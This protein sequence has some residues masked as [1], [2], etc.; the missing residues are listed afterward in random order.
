MV[1]DG[2][3]FV[4]ICFDFE[5]CVETYSLKMF[6]RITKKLIKNRNNVVD[7]HTYIYYNIYSVWAKQKK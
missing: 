7:I 3:A 2:F 6:A 4:D 5:S 1:R